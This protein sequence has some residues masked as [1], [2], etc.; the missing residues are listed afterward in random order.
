MA[1]VVLEHAHENLL[2]GLLLMGDAFLQQILLTSL[3]KI[4]LHLSLETKA[5]FVRSLF[6]KFFADYVHP[7]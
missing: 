3:I 1:I 5:L 6:Y 2:V 7:S 4:P